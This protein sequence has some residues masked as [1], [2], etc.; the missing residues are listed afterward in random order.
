MRWNSSTS[1]ALL[2]S[3]TRTPSL[4]AR[5]M[6]LRHACVNDSRH[7]RSSSSVRST[8]TISRSSSSPAGSSS[9]VR[10]FQ[11][12]RWPNSVTTLFSSHQLD[13]AFET[14]ARAPAFSAPAAKGPEYSGVVESNS[15]PS[16]RSPNGRVAEDRSRSGW[17]MRQ[18][19]ESTV[20]RRGSAPACSRWMAA[21]ST[22]PNTLSRAGRI[23]RQRAP[24]SMLSASASVIRGL[25]SPFVEPPPARQ[26]PRRSSQ[27]PQ[28]ETQ[29]AMVHV[30]DIEL[31]SLLPAQRCAAVHLRPA[32]DPGLH[33]EP[34]ALPGRVLLDLLLDRGTRP[35]DRHLSPHDVDQVRDLV[36]GE[37]AQQRTDA[38]HPRVAGPQRLPHLG[39]SRIRPHDH[40]AQLV[41]LEPVAG[42]ADPPL[43][44]DRG[45]PRLHADGDR[46]G[47][48]QGGREHQAERGEDNVG[49]AW[50]SAAHLVPSTFSHVTAVPE[51]IR[52][53]SPA[54]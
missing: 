12:W 35:D 7:S 21:N 4:R 44:V 53:H 38:G 46:G 2:A 9:S 3:T 11:G 5:L 34:T 37:P 45:P 43:A 19:R 51:R 39:R 15:V 25:A 54:R 30:P 52:S 33:F 47:E 42:P 18:L 41:H 36:E 27:D 24:S 20:I 17:A 22:L 8:Y 29:R 31:D 14:A 13:S 10:A 50:H 23:S 26:Q 40:R 28:V 1:A 6:F 32:G 49:H 48:E 16:I